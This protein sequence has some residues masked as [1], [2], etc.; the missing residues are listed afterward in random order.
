MYASV[1]AS[2]GLRKS[3]TSFSVLCSSDKE[4][5]RERP[6]HLLFVSVIPSP[7]CRGPSL[8]DLMPVDPRWS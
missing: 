4:P 6:H 5:R 1:L 7:V 2:G 3:L 8:R